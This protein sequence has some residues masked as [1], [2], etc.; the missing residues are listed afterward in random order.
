MGSDGKVVPGSILCVRYTAEEGKHY[1]GIMVNGKLVQDTL[2]AVTADAEVKAVFEE[3]QD[4]RCITL[5]V[6][7]GQPSTYGIG[8]DNDNTPVKIDWGDGAL[9]DIVDFH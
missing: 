2:F 1:K 9:K 4:E 6:P 8:A 3:Q 7:A 5:T